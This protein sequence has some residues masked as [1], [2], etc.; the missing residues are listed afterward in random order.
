M[1]W[2]GSEVDIEYSWSYLWVGSGHQ[3]DSSTYCDTGV[4][5]ADRWAGPDWKADLSAGCWTVP[6]TNHN[7][8]DNNISHH[9]TQMKEPDRCVIHVLVTSS[10]RFSSWPRSS[11][12]LSSRFCWTVRLR[13]FFR[14]HSSTG[15]DLSWLW[16]LTK[17]TINIQIYIRF[18]LIF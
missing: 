18:N 4:V 5:S 9:T 17:D 6:S 7:R 12:R 8:Q 10:V 13:R 2:R 1:W 15:S 11:G 3:A 16:L 14:V